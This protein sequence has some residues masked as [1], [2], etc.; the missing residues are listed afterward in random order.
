[1]PCS[2][3]LLDASSARRFTN[4]SMRVMSDESWLTCAAS[5]FIF[6]SIVLSM[7]TTTFG[8]SEPHNSAAPRLVRLQTGNDLLAVVQKVSRVRKA[9]VQRRLTGDAV[10]PVR[11]RRHS[12]GVHR[13]HDV[14]L[15][16]AY[17]LDNLASELPRI[18]QFPVAVAEEY[19]LVRAYRFHRRPLL[20]LAYHR[21]PLARHLGVG[22]SLIAI[23][24]NDVQHMAA[25]THP[26]RNRARRP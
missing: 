24:A 26:L 17:L 1:M 21:E 16:P 23:G 10:I 12:H 3:A 8:L 6:T 11:V 2:A 9:G 7:S 25:F 22:R 14:R 5:A 20:R 13:Q 15:P 4:C 19:H 18:L